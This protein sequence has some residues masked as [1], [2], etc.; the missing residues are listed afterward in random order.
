MPRR[1][2]K[3]SGPVQ[4][5][6]PPVSASALL[7]EVDGR[8]FGDLDIDWSLYQ[9]QNEQLFDP[10][11][12]LAPNFA[13]VEDQPTTALSAAI[14]R[15]ASLHVDTLDC[16]GSFPVIDISEDGTITPAELGTCASKVSTQFSFDE[17]FRLTTEFV[18]I[19]E[20]LHAIPAQRMHGPMGMFSYEMD[21]A[22]SSALSQ[23][24]PDHGAAAAQKG[25]NTSMRPWS[26]VDEATVLLLASC[27]SRLL[28]LY[29]G[30][31]QRM[32]MCIEH[33]L[34]PGSGSDWKVIL[35]KVQ[36]GSLSLPPLQV[37][38]AS[39]APS[40]ATSSMYMVMITTLSTQLWERVGLLLRTGDGCASGI[41]D[42]SEANASE[43]AWCRMKDGT[44]N[45][46]LEIT[47]VQHLLQ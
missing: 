46:K 32:Q 34:R 36:V 41:M 8:S 20:A 25:M 44:N 42:W 27:H 39:P 14:R 37:D 9:S 29:S 19:L 33:S 6:V 47:R 4:D 1:P 40:K 16:L 24:L 18:E 22:K 7:E 5:T 11:N 26:H 21:F 43:L 10:Y 28:Q 3:H 12:G 15:L 45:L 38:Q 35:P 30:V 31:I 2:S 17:L 13:Y 23:P